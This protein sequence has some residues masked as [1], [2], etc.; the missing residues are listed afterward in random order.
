MKFDFYGKI[1]SIWMPSPQEIYITALSEGILCRRRL[2]SAAW[3]S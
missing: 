1:G 2:I 3:I